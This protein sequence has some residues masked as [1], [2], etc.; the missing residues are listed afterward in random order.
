MRYVC[1][2]PPPFDTVRATG[3]NHVLTVMANVEQVQQ[4]VTV[5]PCQSSQISDDITEHM[6]GF[7]A[8]RRPMSG[9]SPS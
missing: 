2:M 5:L 3:A 6:D 1:E 4:P 9:V 8:L 7:V